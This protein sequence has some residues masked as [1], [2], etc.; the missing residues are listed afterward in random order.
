MHDRRDHA[1]TGSTL[2]A[3]AVSFGGLILVTAVTYPVGVLP[4]IATDL[5]T[6]AGSAGL[7]LTVSG[8]MLAVVAWVTGVYA[9]NADRRLLLVVAMAGAGA[10]NLLSAAAPSYPVLLLGRLAVGAGAGVFWGIAAGVAPV[11]V[12]AARVPRATAVIFGAAAAASAVGVPLTTAVGTASGWRSGVVV[13]AV[14]SAIATAALVGL[15]PRLRPREQAEGVDGAPLGHTVRRIAGVLIV[16]SLAV[17]G[18]FAAFTFARPVL[19]QISGFSPDAVPVLLSAFGFAGIAGT[20]LAGRL[21]PASPRRAAQ[22][23]AGSMA[24]AVAALAAIG[25]SPMVAVLAFCVWG[26]G[27]GALGVTLPLWVHARATSDHGRAAAIYIAVFNAAIAAGAAM[28][29]VAVDLTGSPPSMAA[30]LIL[31]CSLLGCAVVAAQATSRQRPPSSGDAA[32][33]PVEAT[34]IG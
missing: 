3:W 28:G 9:R 6:S 19:E 24:A 8:L 1:R 21:A 7:M 31:T 10:G 23:I 26:A 32:S 29:G 18:Q 33:G 12:P 13:L 20:M 15:L 2:A 22:L 30:P 17:A 25:G 16:A 5:D 11:L 4:Q 14:L 34:R 27:Y